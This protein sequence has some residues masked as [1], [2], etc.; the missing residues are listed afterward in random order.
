MWSASVHI[1]LPVLEIRC[2]HAS[3]VCLHMCAHVDTCHLIACTTRTV[4]CTHRVF[5]CTCHAHACMQY[6]CLHFYRVLAHKLS[7]Y[8][9]SWCT[10]TRWVTASAQ[11]TCAHDRG[12]HLYRVHAHTMCDCT[13]FKCLLMRPSASGLISVCTRCPCQSTHLFSCRHTTF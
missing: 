1:G 6:D 12:L 5:A 4:V 9:C 8:M 3:C 7:E 11:G 2:L 10:H 13:C